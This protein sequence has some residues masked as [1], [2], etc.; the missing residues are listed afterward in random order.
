MLVGPSG[1]Q[2]MGGRAGWACG[3]GCGGTRPGGRIIP[4]RLGGG[5]GRL[6]FTIGGRMKGGGPE[7]AS[8]C[9]GV[10]YQT[11]N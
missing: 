9:C 4:P 1:G 8:Q 7:G 3:G 6:R 10:N 5:G 2:L 11:I